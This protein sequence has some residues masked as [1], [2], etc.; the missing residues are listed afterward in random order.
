M[1]YAKVNNLNFYYEIHGEGLPVVVINGLGMDLSECTLVTAEL[2]K[3]Y[4]VLTFDN[5][6]A[7]RSDKPNEPY[8]IEQMAQDTAGV[9]RSAGFQKG[10][11]IGISMG[12]RIAMDL[13]LT[14]PKMVASLVLTSTSTRA[15]NTNKLRRLFNFYVIPRLPIFK[16]KYPQPY[17]AF[18]RQRSA[19]ASYDCSDRLKQIHMP[20][21]I[22]HGRSDKTVPLERAE[23]MHKILNESQLQV[24]KGGHMFFLLWDRLSY[25]NAVNKFLS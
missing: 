22:A 15:V 11:V 18:A 13:A 4:K 12:G 24:F 7:G 20:V 1:P 19:S 23:Q 25:L 2:A 8:T 3:T 9:M 6:G 5:R 21:L 16:G 14:H 10:S 17:Y